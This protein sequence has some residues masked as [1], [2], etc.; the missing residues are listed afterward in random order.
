MIFRWQ[1]CYGH[2]QNTN[3]MQIVFPSRDITV[4]VIQ[5][6]FHSFHSLSILQDIAWFRFTSADRQVNV[7]R[8]DD[9]IRKKTWEEIPTDVTQ[10]YRPRIHVSMHIICNRRESPCTACLK[11]RMPWWLGMWTS[12]LWRKKEKKK[13]SNR[14]KKS[15]PT[16][17][18]RSDASTVYQ[19]FHHI[20]SGI[21]IITENLRQQR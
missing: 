6:L 5:A 17:P 8:Y 21:P 12:N 2:N 1:F 9:L 7:P 14:S 4:P 16:K 3:M 19:W 20:C 11:I 18:G 13:T 15:K 10:R